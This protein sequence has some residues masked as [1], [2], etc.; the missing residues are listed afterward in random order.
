MGPARTVCHAML[1]FSETLVRT[2]VSALMATTKVG[3]AYARL[4]YIP[5]KPAQCPLPTA[6][7]A[8]A[9]P[10]DRF[11]QLRQHV[12]AIT[13]TTMTVGMRPARPAT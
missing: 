13:A 12:P 6:P 2:A 9:V 1:V 3:L 10:S 4:A 11:Y 7:P 5:A 8:R